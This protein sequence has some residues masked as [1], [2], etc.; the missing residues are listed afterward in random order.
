[1][2]VA[3]FGTGNMG[4]PLAKLAVESGY[5]V[6]IGAR[7]PSKAIALARELGSKIKGG[8]F[9]AAASI[10]GL[11]ILA[12]PYQEAGDVLTA[13]GDITGKVIID[14]TNPVSPD[15]M[16]LTIG[17]STSAAEQ[18]AA[19]APTAHVVKAFNTIFAQ[20]LPREARGGQAKIQVFTAAD[21]EPARQVVEEFIEKAGFEPINA[22]PLTNARFIEPVAELNIHFGYALGWGTSIAPAWSKV[23]A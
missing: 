17:H 9:E 18:I 5:D 3:I 7:D 14:V 23:P 8:G 11:I 22:G 19:L 15:Y 1:M 2:N 16:S 20:L 4:R 12:V 10:S 13:A 6:V 21:N